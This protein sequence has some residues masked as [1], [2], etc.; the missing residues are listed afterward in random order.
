MLQFK[1]I[2]VFLAPYIFFIMFTSLLI[3]PAVFL[4]GC[5]RTYLSG[6][7]TTFAARAGSSQEDESSAAQVEEKKEIRPLLDRHVRINVPNKPLA[8]ILK[9]KN[10]ESGSVF[11]IYIDLQTRSLLFRHEDDVLKRYRIG[12]GQNTSLGDK[13]KEGDLRTPRGE[14]YICSKVV[15]EKSKTVKEGNLGT[16]WMQ[17]SYPNIEAADRGLENNSISKE[18]YNKIKEAIENKE[19]P[20]QN[21]P[22]GSAIGIHGGARHSFSRDWTAGCIGMYDKDIEEI[23]DYLKVGDRVQIR[24]GYE[25]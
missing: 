5:E 10:I 21:T 16:R 6:S 17:L 14:F 7:K 11:N 19:I 22:L 18:V 8:E 3:I 2:S 1:K 4:S 15:Y 9:E 13:E 25:E 24:W 23:F 20:P 12:A